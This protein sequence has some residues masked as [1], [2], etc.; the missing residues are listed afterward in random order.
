MSNL[1]EYYTTLETMN[2][3]SSE[4]YRYMFSIPKI[5]EDEEDNKNYN[6]CVWDSQGKVICKNWYFDEKNGFLKEQ[7]GAVAS[8]AA[9]DVA[10]RSKIASVLSGSTS[11]TAVV[12]N[13]SSSSSKP[14]AISSS[15]V[16]AD[17][18]PVSTNANK[19]TDVSVAEKIIKF[20]GFS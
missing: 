4:E 8:V 5:D 13:N 10:N 3:K 11:S 12:P 6:S 18:A 20:I 2:I 9:V 19:N 14:I 17:T 7:K 16:Q 1:D 15:E